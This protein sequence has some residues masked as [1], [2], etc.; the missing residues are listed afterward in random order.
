M[1]LPLYALRLVKTTHLAGRFILIEIVDV[2]Y[3]IFIKPS[4]KVN[5]T[6]S[7]TVGK[8]SR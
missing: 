7:F 4:L 3:T 1:Y 2:A 5:S 8:R 6:I